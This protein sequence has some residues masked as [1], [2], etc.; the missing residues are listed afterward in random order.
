MEATN[1]IIDEYFIYHYINTQDKNLQNS[2]Y[3]LWYLTFNT[4]AIAK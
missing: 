3:G 2:H 4:L 1:E